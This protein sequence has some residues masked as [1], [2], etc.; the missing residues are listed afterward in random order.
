[1]SK[2]LNNF[3]AYTLIALNT[4]EIQEYISNGYTVADIPY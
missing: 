3:V 2:A 1:L 4:C